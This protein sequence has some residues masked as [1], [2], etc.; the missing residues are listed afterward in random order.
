MGGIGSLPDLALLGLAVAHHT[1][2]MIIL[3]IHLSGHGHA[4]RAGQTLTQRAGG[5]V[6][7][8]ALVHRRVALEHG[9]FLPQSVQ[10]RLREEAHRGQTGVLDGAHMAFGKNHPVTI[11]P[12]GILGI[13][14]HVLEIA[15][16]D[17]VCRRK[18]AARMTGLG[19]IDHIN[20]LHAHLYGGVFQFLNGNVFHKNHLNKSLVLRLLCNM[21][22]K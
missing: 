2:Y 7:A 14:V 13:Q 4:D 8:G 3:L 9:A 21:S 18:G 1:E 15:G 16:S 10:L 22:D 12:A 6:D 17:K 19:L 11:R 5:D 20:D